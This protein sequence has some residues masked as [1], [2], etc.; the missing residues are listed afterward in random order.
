MNSCL[1]LRV[2]SLLMCRKGF[3]SEQEEASGLVRAPLP[4]RPWLILSQR[5]ISRKSSSN[6]LHKEAT[7]P[8]EAKWKP[9]GLH[10]TNGND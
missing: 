9:W 3:K 8:R 4:R 7:A 6:P 10:H 5:A 2:L 1:L